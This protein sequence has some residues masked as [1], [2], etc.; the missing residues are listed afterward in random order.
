MLSP[1]LLAAAPLPEDP[2]AN[3]GTHLELLEDPG[4]RLDLSQAQAAFA[5]GE[6][7]PGRSSEP[8]FGY[9]DSAVWLRLELSNPAGQV[10]RRLLELDNHYM[11][12]FTLWRTQGGRWVPLEM[13]DHLPFGQRPVEYRNFIAPLTFEPGQ[14][15]VLWG[16]VASKNRLRLTFNLWELPAFGARLQDEYLVYGLYFGLIAV[17]VGYNLFL[18][19]GVGDR[20]YL[21]YSAY[22][23]SFGLTAL[24]ITGL[25]YQYLYPN[26]PWLKDRT[27]FVLMELTEFW[28]LWFA[29]WFLLTDKASPRLGRVLRL[30]GGFTLAN[31][32]LALLPSAFWVP[33]YFLYT[34][35]PSVLL[36]LFAGLRRY[37]Q[38]FRPARYFLLAFVAFFAGVLGFVAGSLGWFVDGPVV[39]NLIYI[40]S[41]A[42]VVLLA[43]ALADRIQLLRHEVERTQAE[44]VALIERQKQELEAQVAQR[45]AELARS[46]ERLAT[47][48]RE[49]N[50]FLS[51]AAHDLKTPVA[52]VNSFA[53]LLQGNLPP[54]AGDC[55]QYVDYIR[56]SSAEMSRLID[57]L[58]DLARIEAQAE[59]DVLAEEV[60]LVPLGRRLLERFEA[61]T[62]LAQVELVLVAPEPEVWAWAVPHW[63]EEAGANLV[64]N[65]LRHAPPSSRV[66]LVLGQAEGFARLEVRDQGPGVPEELVPTLFERYAQAERTGLNGGLGLY[67]VRLL[68]ERQGGRADYRPASG[69]GAI[70]GLSL[71]QP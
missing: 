65:A 6:F 54:Q 2:R 57:R 4:A 30:Y 14:T 53:A 19:A 50:R 26:Q 3:L 21:L 10:Q 22:I 47:L 7:A 48:D 64:A 27:I 9:R 69:T 24:C 18:F 41:A 17:M 12:R 52:A 55:G 16:R 8:D 44:M 43:L 40:G 35:F 39:R 23:A 25:D 56:R 63:V 15:Q 37:G 29:R 46:N 60:D 59:G 62:H 11:D 68:A 67:I 32:G 51:I 66:E 5:R 61:Q 1:G 28:L 71:P 42:E 58:L 45:T 31:A 34:S 20:S 36:A 70:F 38:G 49:K 33:T 13:G